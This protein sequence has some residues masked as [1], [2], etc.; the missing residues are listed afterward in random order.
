[1][2]DLVGRSGEI[3]TPDRLLPKRRV[4]VNSEQFQCLLVRVGFVSFMLS[5]PQPALHLPSV[6]MFLQSD[7]SGPMLTR[8]FD[9]CHPTSNFFSTTCSHCVASA[10]PGGELM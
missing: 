4:S 9:Q 5:S 10:L 1:V 6:A 2:F 8:E 7:G 3:R